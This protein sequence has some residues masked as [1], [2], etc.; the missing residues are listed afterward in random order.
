MSNLGGLLASQGR[1]A[2]AE[3]LLRK[4]TDGRRQVLGDQHPAFNY[5]LNELIAC[6]EAQEK[7]A[8]AETL[9]RE[10]LDR[11]RRREP[12]NEAAVSSA[13]ASSWIQPA[14]PESIR[15]RRAAAARVPHPARAAASRWA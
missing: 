12:P 7:L 4:A 15:G 2:E 13:L 10:Q 11:V 14:S 8:E 9:R 6:L 5:T 3:P 1:H